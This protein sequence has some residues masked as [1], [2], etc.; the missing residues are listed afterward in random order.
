MQAMMREGD[1]DALIQSTLLQGLLSGDVVA[2]SIRARLKL[3]RENQTMRRRLTM[4]RIRTEQ[5]KQK[6]LGIE[7]DARSK[8][9]APWYETVNHI[10]EIYG[11]PAVNPPLLPAAQVTAEIISQPL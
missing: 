1:E 7:A 3:Q 6:L 8:P 9:A 11:L 4:S 5:V 10:R 2:A